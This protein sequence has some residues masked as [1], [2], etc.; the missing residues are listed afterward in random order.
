MSFLSSV[1]WLFPISCLTVLSLLP[2]CSK[3]E[4]D[5]PIVTANENLFINEIY[6]SGDDW[7]E[8]FNNTAQAKD[9]SGYK[10]Y[11]DVANKYTL[12]AGT[13]VPANG[14]LVIYCDDLNTGL[15]TNFRLTSAGETVYL[16]SG[17]D[18][19]DKVIFPALDNGQSYGRFPDGSS[20]FAISGSTTQGTSNGATN[21]PAI[22]SVKRNPLVVSMDDD[23]TITASFVSVTGLSSVKLFYR[24]NQ[25]GT[26]ES[27]DMSA[28][29]STY[30]ATIPAAASEGRIDYYVEATNAA[31]TAQNPNSAPDKTH[32]YVMSDDALPNLVI[33]EFMAF[34]TSC[35]PDIDGGVEEFDDWVEIRNNGD[36]PVDVGGM[37]LSDD[38]SNPFNYQIPDTNPTLTT[39]QAGGYLLIWADNDTD[40]GELHLDFGLSTDGEDLGLYYFD[41]RTIDDVTFGPQ[42]ENVSLARQPDGTGEFALENTPTTHAAN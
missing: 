17:T 40:Q 33:N 12:P 3:D 27:L 6:A 34:N 15:H 39:I 41:G 29:G 23:V 42:A 14:F 25:T 20:N 5:D 31:G 18:V 10:I 8:L 37:Y 11:D 38:K 4:D 28:S 1:K 13:S 9:I 2:S 36:T 19:I 7:I 26:Y 30:V 22:I 16:E 35:C 24:F 21:A 32:F